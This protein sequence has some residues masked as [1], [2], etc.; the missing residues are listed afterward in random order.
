M[1]PVD[2][3]STPAAQAGYQVG[4][5]GMGYVAP[6]I[7]FGKEKE[8][9]MYKKYRLSLLYHWFREAKFELAEL[10]HFCERKKFIPFDLS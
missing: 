6:E 2:K 1:C 5:M 8:L 7:A 3:G 9:D 4:A 10:I